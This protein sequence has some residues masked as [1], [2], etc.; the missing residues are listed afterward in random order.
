[1]PPAEGGGPARAADA[2]ILPEGQEAFE[3]ILAESPG[4]PQGPVGPATA[5]ATPQQAPAQS[6][7]AAAG[8]L[9]LARPTAE[10][11]VEAAV[12]AS[13]QGSLQIPSVASDAATLSQAGVGMTLAVSADTAR[14]GARVAPDL[15]H[16][17]KPVTADSATTAADASAKDTSGG[18]TREARGVPLDT[19]APIAENRR[20]TEGAEAAATPEPIGEAATLKPSTETESRTKAAQAFAAMASIGVA[21]PP[22]ASTA[23]VIRSETTQGAAPIKI[24]QT[25]QAIPAAVPPRAD[26]IKGVQTQQPVPAA[27]HADTV[28]GVQSQQPVLAAVPPQAGPVKGVQ[29][30]QPVPAAVAPQAGP[31]KGVQIQQPI[32]AA[33]APQAGPAQGV[34]TQQ[35]VPAAVA[36]QAGPAQGVQSQQPIPAAVAPQAGPVQGVQTQQPIPAA[37]APQAGPAQGVQTQP[38]I[39]AAVPLRAGTA[40]SAQTWQSIPAADTPRA[41]T[42][43]VDPQRSTLRAPA[44]DPPMA[45]AQKTATDDAPILKT[46]APVT[47]PSEIASDEPEATRQDSADAKPASD[48]AAKA[49]RSADMPPAP[50]AATATSP[51]TPLAAG[52]RT[53]QGPGMTG[54]VAAQQ[55]QQLAAAQA[56]PKPLAEAGQNG[57]GKTLSGADTS[58]TGTGRVV[59]QAQDKAQAVKAAE[60]TPQLGAVAVSVQTAAAAEAAVQAT[61]RPAAETAAAT[62]AGPATK[63]SL[64]ESRIK[65]ALAALPTETEASPEPV[66]AG[67]PVP[68]ADKAGAAAPI[69]ASAPLAASQPPP[70]PVEETPQRDARLRESP[71]AEPVR[72][73]AAAPAQASVAEMVVK[74]T[75]TAAG[76]A[77]PTLEGAAQTSSSAPMSFSTTGAPERAGHLTGGGEAAAAQRAA[78]PH[79][80]AHQ[81]SQALAD[82]GNRTVELTLSPEELG[83]VRMTL[84][85]NDGAITVTVQAE[86]PETLDLMRRN[87]DSLARDFRDMGY[88]N[89]G[90]DFGQQTDQRPSAQERAAESALQPA[91]PERDGLARFETFPTPLQAAPGTASGGLDLRI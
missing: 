15:P 14:A 48:E 3:T 44:E 52:A 13:M 26:T 12:V 79:A 81:M 73:R 9:D 91:A 28:K 7:E 27:P 29:T 32:P 30:Q 72:N 6:F 60:P 65:A 64:A 25:Q 77:T 2:R 82:A 24:A 1:M 49:A 40:D 39:P 55:P 8:V 21:P 51:Q 86:R 41:D 50:F 70:G 57:A 58:A 37:V 66:T 75:E 31:V 80:I 19:S 34:Q 90:F 89:V 74:A 11:A 43:E 38:P 78:S 69:V 20:A 33:V 22:A 83:K 87:I 18:P 76:P 62:A 16:R 47:R 10:A 85:S 5:S 61:S 45:A 71:E 4:L 68:A 53:A 56:G 88:S 54:V 67:A 46:D 42:A 84:T 59:E 36:P 35:P 17:Q 23:P 63:V